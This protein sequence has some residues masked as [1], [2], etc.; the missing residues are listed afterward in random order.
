MLV[1]RPTRILTIHALLA[2]LWASLL[3]YALHAFHDDPASFFFNPHSDASLRLSQSRQQ[4]VDERLRTILSSPPRPPSS[5]D[6]PTPA[7]WPKRLCL[8]IVSDTKKRK[9]DEVS[10]MR[11][12]ASLTM[13]LSPSE[14]QSMHVI[15]LLSGIPGQEAGHFAFGKGYMTSLVDEVLVYQREAEDGQDGNGNGNGGNLTDTMGPLYREVGYGNRGEGLVERARLDQGVLVE[16][17]RG[18][19]ATYMALVEPDVVVVR[20]WYARLVRALSVVEHAARLIGEGWVYLRLFHYPESQWVWKAE[21]WVGLSVKWMVVYMSGVVLGMGLYRWGFHRKGAGLRSVWGES[22]PWLSL[23]VW[24]PVFVRLFL[25]MGGLAG[26]KHHAA[27]WGAG[28]VREMMQEGCCGHGVVFPGDML[29]EY[30][31]LFR[32]PPFEVPIP[33]LLDRLAEEKALSKWG[34]DPSLLV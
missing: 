19:Q 3:S 21:T 26:V 27:P 1:P 13:D 12:L 28:G 17:C 14:R 15:V 20:D 4:D 11:T 22:M 7:H 24:I 31:E 6:V 33:T 10:L 23:A 9:H 8:G 5:H 29:G 2:L 25:L 18:T 16:A 34:M 32:Q 30:Q